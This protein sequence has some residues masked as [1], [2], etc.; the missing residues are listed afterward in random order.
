MM[1]PSRKRLQQL[2]EAARLLDKGQIKQAA[3]LCKRVIGKTPEN[4]KA[5][6]LM[7]RIQEAAGS[8]NE[9]LNSYQR[10]IQADPASADAYTNIAMLYHKHGAAQE[11]E[12]Y[13]RASLR[14]T[15]GQPT[16]LFNL[17][18]L[19]QSVDRLDDAI[20]FYEDAIA[21]NPM[22]AKAHA[23][24]GY[25]YRDTNQPEKALRH[26]QQASMLAPDTAEIHF[27]QALVLQDLR[28][29]YEASVCLDKAVQLNNKYSQALYALGISLSYLSREQ[30]AEK[31]LRAALSLDKEN[32]DILLAL[33]NV[34]CDLDRFEKAETMAR[35]A[36]KLDSDNLRVTCLQCRLELHKGNYQTALRLIE[37][38]LSAQED[39]NFDVTMLASEIFTKTGKI[40]TAID[41]L[42]NLITHSDSLTN[43]QLIRIHFS[44]G[45]YYDRKKSYKKAFSNYEKGNRK[46]GSEFIPASFS[47]DISELISVFDRELIETHSASG[48]RST[49]PVFIIG[50]PRSGTT[51]VE[52]ILDS[53]SM[54]FGAGELMLITE[55]RK[56]LFDLVDSESP[57]P[58]FL[59]AL[60]PTAI[61]KVA[62]TYLEHI[63]KLSPNSRRITDKLPHNF[64]NLGLINILFP[65]SRV[66]H[67]K[68][69]PV[70]TCLSNYFQDF[71]Q[72]HQNSCDLKNMGMFYNEYLRLMEHWRNTI[73]LPIFDVQYENL[74]QDPEAGVRS[75]TEFCGLPW[76]DACLSFYKNMRQVKTASCDQVNQ[77]IYTTSVERWRNY[78]EYITPL[79]EALGTN[80]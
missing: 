79:L 33:S 4:S 8:A 68:R 65:K 34:L 5:W 66:I 55:L 42:E 43:E 3:D 24:L 2:K 12:K 56:T 60:T 67:C 51:L 70:D 35:R 50:V 64:L 16:T 53:H 76:E 9:A 62:D 80:R 38:W 27:N 15:P 23:N 36:V 74:I 71:K 6:L 61:R 18:A 73:T 25:I 17:A 59:R 19:I 47:Q 77:P 63:K 39:I 10:C 75:I 48:S 30:E 72:T 52:Q 32:L 26:Y 69:S 46:R 41:M 20:K 54:V 22:Y 40:Q 28:R 7:G 49:L 1:N 11:A 45:K 78:E 37:P 29:H 57:Y 14:I 31:T 13:Y 44:L 21:I 58:V